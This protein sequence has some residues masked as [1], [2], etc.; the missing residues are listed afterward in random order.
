MYEQTI[1]DHEESLIADD[2]A[3]RQSY[4]LRALEFIG[5]L[6]DM[7]FDTEPYDGHDVEFLE[8]LDAAGII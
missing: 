6:I 7:N 1:Q 2:I 8:V 3:A 4:L 5:E